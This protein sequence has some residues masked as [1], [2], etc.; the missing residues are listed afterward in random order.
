[1]TSTHIRIP[2]EVKSRL[3][4]L[5]NDGE[6]IGAVITRIIDYYESAGGI[7]ESVNT[8]VNI[9]EFPVNESLTK[10]LQALT[11][12][13]E[14]LEASR[15]PIPEVTPPS[16]QSEIL[17]EYTPQETP[18]KGPLDERITLTPE[19]IKVVTERMKLLRSQ[20]LSNH[21]I[22]AIT[23]I[24]EGSIKKIL[25]PNQSLKSLTKRQYESL[26]LQ[27]LSD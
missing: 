12:R 22:H 14:A 21:D 15:Q 5:M 1:M 3:D 20:G 27:S 6:S 16:V 13:V 19:K 8:Q 10:E 7:N 9:S 23:G 25:S 2:V 24:P 4:T 17:I 11:A 26:N 18:L